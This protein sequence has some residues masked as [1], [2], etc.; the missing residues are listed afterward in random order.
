MGFC[1]HLVSVIRFHGCGYG[2]THL[3]ESGHSERVE[4]H[5]SSYHEVN[6]L[7]Y[8][9]QE[10]VELVGHSGV[11]FVC[12]KESRWILIH[13]NKLTLTLTPDGHHAMLKGMDGAEAPAIK[14]SWLQVETQYLVIELRKKLEVGKTYWLYTEFQGE[15]TDDL[16]GFYR[17]EYYEDGVRRVVATT[18]M[19]P[20]D[21]RK[22]FPCFDEPMMKAVFHMTLLHA[23]GTVALANG[24]EIGTEIITMNHQRVLQTKFEPTKKMSTYLLAFIVSNFAFIKA[25]QR[26]K[27]LIRI[28]ARR[29][30][31]ESGQGDYGL[32]ITGH[33]LDF[34]QYYYNISYPLHKS[35][36]VALP[37]FSA[38][39]MENWG[40]VT[41]RESVLLYDPQISSTKDKEVVV[42]VISHE[43]AHMWFGNLVTMKWWND[44]W[45]NEGF[46]TYVSYLGANEAEPTWSIKD[47]MVLYEIQPALATDGLSSSHPLSC[48]EDEINTPEQ[49]NALFNT[50]TYKKGAAVLR[51]LSEVLSE[52]VF[53]KGLHAYL[54]QFAYDNTVYTDLWGKIQDVVDLNPEV[55]LPATISEF[56]N[57]WTLQMGFPL[58]TIDTQTGTISQKHFLLDPDTEVDS[59]SV[60]QYEWFVPIKWMKN[61]TDMGQY[62]LL[63]KT[64]SHLPMKTNSRWVL[65]NLNVSGFYRVNYDA[66]NWQR[67]LSQL[68]VDHT[69]IPIINRAQIIDDAFSLARAKIIKQTMALST[70][71]YLSKDMEYVPWDSA[72]RNLNYLSYMLE[73]TEVHGA[74]QNYMRQKVQPLFNYFKKITSDWT[75]IPSRHTD[76]Y[77]QINAIS[78]GCQSGVEGCMNLTSMWYKKW[79]E[80]PSKNPIH[81]NLRSTVYCH[82]IS[83]GDDVEWDF[84]WKMYNN[85]TISA[86]S[87]KLMSALACTRKTHL[88]ERYLQFT[89][90]PYKIRKQDALSVMVHAAKSV[91]GQTLVWSFIKANWHH[92]LTEYDFLSFRRVISAV[93]SKFSTE[94]ELK[95]LQQFRSE[96]SSAGLESTVQVVDLLIKRTKAN[97][98]WV[99]EN[100]EQIKKWLI[101]ESA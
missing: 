28:W 89:L 83:A 6:D 79:M 72:I 2:D 93:T 60:Y 1:F 9:E 11:A 85:S 97:M 15:L 21:A 101:E 78:L 53:A 90:D 77:N 40:L 88:L 45:L 67:L 14:K 87:K 8:S 74:M 19:Q 18:Q 48:L 73:Q 10:V 70:T 3:D 22:A 23:P 57:R 37:D 32:N 43:L 98:E 64:D 27:V 76:Q 65:A 26:E 81:P 42:T 31:I 71:K 41:Y 30:A 99:A 86:E 63:K 25:P 38:G 55:S 82:A 75:Q 91:V 66:Q 84:G 16:G 69:V 61:G 50:I 68:T 12:M 56:M 49:I 59:T 51:M 44:L 100:K 52:P 62:W 80:N 5:G 7:I 46:A 92:L 34:F 94:T 20:T 95:Q 13:S 24:M 47:L 58:V 39:A 36:Q 54:N 35:D 29:K 4:A 96:A 33:V 17:S